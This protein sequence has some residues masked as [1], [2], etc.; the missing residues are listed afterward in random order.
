MKHCNVTEK[1]HNWHNNM[2]LWCKWSQNLLQSLVAFWNLFG[3]I[4]CNAGYYNRR[5]SMTGCHNLLNTYVLMLSPYGSLCLLNGVQTVIALY[6]CVR[7]YW[8]LSVWCILSIDYK[9]FWSLLRV[10]FVML[11]VS[12]FTE[13]IWFDVMSFLYLIFVDDYYKRALWCY[14]CQNLLNSFGMIY[15]SYFRC[16]VF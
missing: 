14:E 15:G 4:K 5:I 7:I 3:L 6:K 2:A 10:G 12:E 13:L 9:M 1:C 16:F 8:P 11:W